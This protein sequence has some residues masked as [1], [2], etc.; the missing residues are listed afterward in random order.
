MVRMETER[1]PLMTRIIAIAVL[2]V[3]IWFLAHF[4]IGLIAG[5]ATVIAIVAAIAAIIWAIRVL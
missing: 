2:V 1:S 4:V 5:L 3:A